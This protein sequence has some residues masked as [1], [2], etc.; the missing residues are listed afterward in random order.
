VTEAGPRAVDVRPLGEGRFSVTADLGLPIFESAR[1][2]VA[3]DPPAARVIDHPLEVLG[4]SVAVT[5][6][7]LGNPHCVVFRDAPVDDETLLRLGKALEG[8]PFFPKRT[9]VEFTTLMGP[10]ELRMRIYERGVGYTRASGTGSASAACAAI[11]A[12]GASRNLRVHCD[13]GDLDVLWEEGKTVRQTGD[14]EVL[15]EGD[16]VRESPA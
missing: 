9:N 13:G 12:R 3:L 5:A 6:L 10:G 7:S 15:F 8:H 16:W 4:T 1:I 14:V 11:L 2:P